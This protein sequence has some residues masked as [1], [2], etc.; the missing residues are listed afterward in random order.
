MASKTKAELKQQVDDLT[1]K[2]T[3]T[4]RHLQIMTVR[5]NK[6][7]DENRRLKKGRQ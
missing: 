6:L 3:L 5:H 7:V 2:L 1:K 4:E